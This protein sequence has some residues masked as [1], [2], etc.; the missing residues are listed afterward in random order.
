METLADLHYFSRAALFI[1]NE[2][3]SHLL[4]KLPFAAIFEVLV[5][6]N[7]TA[8]CPPGKRGSAPLESSRN[9]KKEKKKKKNTNKQ[10]LEIQL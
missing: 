4:E 8:A 5:V 9:I 2:H 3:S 10:T 1:I 7:T 6:N